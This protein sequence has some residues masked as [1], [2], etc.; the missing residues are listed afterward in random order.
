M[1]KY[2]WLQGLDSRIGSGL[3]WQWR[4]SQSANGWPIL[5]QGIVYTNYLVPF[6]S[7]TKRWIWGVEMQSM[8]LGDGGGWK[9]RPCNSILGLSVAMYQWKGRDHRPCYKSVN[10]KSDSKVSSQ[11]GRPIQCRET[12]FHLIFNFVIGDIP[13]WGLIT[14]VLPSIWWHP[15]W[16]QVM[17]SAQTG[18]WI[19]HLQHF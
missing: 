2:A 8:L 13:P 12:A 1:A 3:L 4:F 7:K 16:F 15:L 18:L 11:D 19:T 14:P 6:W 9:P 10:H 17:I 5:A